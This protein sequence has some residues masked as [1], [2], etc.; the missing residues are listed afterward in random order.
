MVKTT[1]IFVKDVMKPAITVPEDMKIIEMLDFIDKRKFSILLVVD[2]DNVLIGFVSE[3]D[4][5]KLVKPEPLSPIAGSVWFDTIEKSQGSRTVK[6]IMD[7][8]I[9]SISPN[10]TIDSALKMMNNYRVRVLP[11][12]DSENK[13]LGVI[14][15]RDI[16]E[17]LLKE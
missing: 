4:L 14:R 8:K 12:I 13:I 1:E 3:Q 9:I 15:L 10:D 16:F 2:K 5:I 7:T 6:E 17:K 11:V